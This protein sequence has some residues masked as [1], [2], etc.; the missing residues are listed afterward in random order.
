MA[1]GLATLQVLDD[2]KLVERSAVQGQKLIDAVNGLKDKHEFLLEARGKGCM[3]GIEFQMPSSLGLKMLWK[4]LHAANDGL[5]AQMIVMPLL[6]KYKVLSQ[7]SGN[8]GDIIRVLPPFVITDED[9]QYFVGSLD[10]VLDE[11]RNP[12]GSMWGLGTKLVKASMA[13]KGKK[14]AEPAAVN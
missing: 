5:F 1:V 7:V 14:E 4:G 9:I 12:L 13:N 10:T 8:H 6:E 11:C 3:V 2:E